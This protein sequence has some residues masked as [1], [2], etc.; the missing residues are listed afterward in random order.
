M[1]TEQSRSR[2]DQ[3]APVLSIPRRYRDPRA[4]AE[5]MRRIGWCE[6]LLAAARA[7]ASP[8][9][10]PAPALQ[11]PGDE[12]SVV[13]PLMSGR[14]LQDVRAALAAGQGKASTGAPGDR[15]RISAAQLALVDA[16]LSGDHQ[17]TALL[18]DPTASAATQFWLHYYAG[19]SAFLFDQDGRAADHLEAARQLDRS[20]DFAELTASHLDRANFCYFLALAYSRPTARGSLPPR[21]AAHIRSARDRF[22]ASA[23]LD[24]AN[25]RSKHLLLEAEAARLLGD[26]A[27]ALS[28]YERAAEAAGQAGMPHERALAHELAGYAYME[29]GLLT[30]ALGCFHAAVAC[31]RAWGATGKAALLERR[32]L[33]STVDAQ[34][35]T[36]LPASNAS[37]FAAAVVH[38]INQPL[39]GI[40]T[41][42][43]ASL[44][45]LER[46]QPNVGEARAGLLN[47]RE[48]ARRAAAIIQSLRGLVQHK[49]ATLLPVRLDEIV[50]DALRSVADDLCSHRIQVVT[51][52][53]A[54]APVRA[55]RIQLQQVVLNLMTN[56]VHAMAETVLAERR[57]V[58]R[59]AVSPDGWAR[60]TVEDRGRGMSDAVQ[61]RIFE[62]FFTTKQAGM[63]VGL[64][65]CRS[66]VE[67][68]CGS[69]EVRSTLGQG[70]TFTVRLPLAPARKPHQV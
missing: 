23:R 49:R 46:D 69:I 6:D 43:D 32:V 33:S 7:A 2:P 44:R 36:T 39:A 45:W 10:A 48:A 50:H 59:S 70:T 5:A 21:G 17:T 61:A 64:A 62:P 16:L 12:P 57:L 11:A 34:T 66:I 63:G 55:D 27:R 14:P 20:G 26:T 28:L 38:E 8:N 40:M 51:H 52:L 54:T 24:P 37:S 68:H 4:G 13:P 56:A 31:Y 25:F 65:I 53:C 30:P 15:E 42:A 18:A 19:M 29:A 22:E 35:A 60:L 41:H 9:P 58:I 47:I 67:A 3:A 1:A